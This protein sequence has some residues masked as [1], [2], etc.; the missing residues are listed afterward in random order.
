[1]QPYEYNE[2]KC[3]RATH[4]VLVGTLENFAADA[5]SLHA[6]AAARLLQLAALLAR[7]SGKQQAPAGTSRGLCSVNHVSRARERST[8]FGVRTQSDLQGFT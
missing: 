2:P 1:M 6:H 5:A 4:E 8:V 3:T 7:C